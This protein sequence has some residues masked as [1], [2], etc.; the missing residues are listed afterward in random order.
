MTFSIVDVALADGVIAKGL[1]ET[2]P[3]G[4]EKSAHAQAPIVVDF[5]SPKL[6]HRIKNGADGEAIV[7][8]LGVKRSERAGVLIYD[9]TAGLGT[10]AFLLACAGFSVVA[11]ERNELVYQLLVD[12]LR[13]WKAVHGD[14]LRLE[15]RQGDAAC[16]VREGLVLG[17][18]HP[19]Y[20]VMLDPMFEGEATEGKSLPKKEMATLRRMLPATSDAE[21]QV[22]FETAVQA[23]TARI[24]VKRPHAAP[25]LVTSDS[26]GRTWKPVRR[27]EGKTARFD[28]YSCR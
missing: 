14:E 9:F 23:A 6:K 2:A 8:A 18:L 10:E 15:F 17:S 11:Y 20:A 3:N 13:R 19:G 1:I 25:D 7:K 4:E 21:L 28:I 12:G 5:Q 24:V 26:S 16:V 22:M 27:L